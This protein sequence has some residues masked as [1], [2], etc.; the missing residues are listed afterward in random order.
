MHWQPIVFRGLVTAALVSAGC[1]AGNAAAAED[2]AADSSLGLRAGEEE[3]SLRSLT[4]EAENRMQIRFE[5]PA[6][7]LDVDPASAPG[8]DW[9]DPLEVLDRTVPD[10]EAPLLA[11]TRGLDSP[12]TARPWLRSFRHG[13]VA[14]FQPELENVERWRLVVADARGREVRTFEGRGE[15]PE[16]IEWDG[17]TADGELASPG[18]VHSYVLEAHDRAGNRRNFAGDSFEIAAYRTGGV[19][20][21]RMIL[22]G[23]H[24]EETAADGTPLLLLEVASR[25]NQVEDVERPV[26][27][28][29]LA[30]SHAQAEALAERVMGAL[31]PRLLGPQ[32]RV[33]SF[34]QVA[35]DAPETAVIE[36]SAA[37]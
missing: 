16:E 36:V 4:V 35:A 11:S 18:L 9:G 15:P 27:I 14:V 28:N 8:L 13:T 12:F 32:T 3:T 2:A 25:V 20:A 30:R 5:R 6:L 26:R 23:K 34:T 7:A 17:R 24:L 10:L 37:P 21:P 33:M 1:F 29:V 31:K 19:T 22:A